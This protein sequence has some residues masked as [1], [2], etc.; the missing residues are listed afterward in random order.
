MPIL[1]VIASSI[2]GN[3]TPPDTG[4]M[5]PIA[6]VNVGSAGAASISFT[7]IPQTYKHLQL[8]LIG[9]D[10][11]S[12]SDYGNMQFNGDTGAN[13][14]SHQLYG[15]GS[16]ATANNFPNNNQIYIHR[17]P[18]SITNTF[19]AVIVDILDYTNINKYKTVRE[20]G[21]YD[22]NGS[23]R[24][25]FSSGMWFGGTIGNSANTITSI[26]ISTGG[27]SWLQYSQFALYGIKG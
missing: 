24:I 15:D 25:S 18:G 19:G 16:S 26:S 2:S 12:G 22:A 7:S 27:S 21:G 6:M 1:G 20:L 13:Y 3:L 5:F 11:A 10:N 23:G 4:S 9:A 8:R 17:I 14:A